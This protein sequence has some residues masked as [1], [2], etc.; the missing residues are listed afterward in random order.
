MPLIP[1]SLAGDQTVWG[2]GKAVSFMPRKYK[3]RGCPDCR[4]VFRAGLLENL[5]MGSNWTEYGDA[6]RRCPN[7]GY[8]GETNE[9]RVQDDTRVQIAK[10]TGK[11]LDE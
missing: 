2:I 10:L 11:L 7:C 4:M 8:V 6:D 9:F 5:T 1:V 3:Y